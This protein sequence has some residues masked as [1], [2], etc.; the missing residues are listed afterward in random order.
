MTLAQ[1]EFT[2]KVGAL[3]QVTDDLKDIEKDSAEGVTTIWTMARK[4]DGSLA[5]P[6]ASLVGIKDSLMNGPAKRAFPD[7]IQESQDMIETGFLF[8][9]LAG[10]TGNGEL[11]AHIIGTLFG[12]KN[13]APKVSPD[14]VNG[15]LGRMRDTQKS[16]DFH[17]F[18]FC[19]LG[20]P[21]RHLKKRLK[22]GQLNNFNHKN[23]LPRTDHINITYQ[24]EYDEN[25]AVRERK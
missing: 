2:Y 18:Q 9:V 14:L 19:E 12:D 23:F 6:L 22:T 15:V 17:L 24:T 25:V 4:N 11:N 20:Q 13:L 7:H 21:H 8:E 3:F 10:M 16:P 1:L 5:A